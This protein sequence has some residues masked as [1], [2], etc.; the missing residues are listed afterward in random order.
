MKPFFLL[1]SLFAAFLLC[2][3]D[4]C[5]VVRVSEGKLHFSDGKSSNIPHWNEE[6]WTHFFFVRHAEKLDDSD[7]PDLSPAGYARAERLGSI[8]ENAG[9]DL[10]FATDK[11]RTQKTA[12]KVHIRART[13][14]VI[15]YPSGNDAETVW[16]QDQLTR[17]RGKRLF[18]VGHSNTVPRI[19]NKL[20]GPG[21]TIPD[22]EAN[23][24]G[25][26][27]VVASRGLGNSKYLRKG[28]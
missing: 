3:C 12:E 16:L 25:A 23:T 28:Y 6:G 8:M 9:L 18:V 11:L 27:F 24:F 13:P 5:K 4:S 22:I 17:N 1:L 14:D 2:G 21:T 26:F 15:T 10:V 19:I 20:M 7:N